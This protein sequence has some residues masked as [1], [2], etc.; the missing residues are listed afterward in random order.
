MRAGKCQARMQ[1]L[2][3]VK[4][5]RWR[6]PGFKPQ[7]LLAQLCDLRQVTFFKKKRVKK[8]LPHGIVGETDQLTRSHGLSIASGPCWDGHFYVPAQLGFG[9]QLFS[10]ILV[11]VLQ[12]RCLADVIEV[13]NQLTLSKGDSGR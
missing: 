6:Q 11:K 5:T 1:S 3:V 12:G 10:Q 2:R 8:N 4:S 7:L 9:P 13:H